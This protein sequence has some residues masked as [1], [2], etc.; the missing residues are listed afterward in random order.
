MFIRATPIEPAAAPHLLAFAQEPTVKV[1][2]TT[3]IRHSNIVRQLVYH[4]WQPGSYC[5]W[6]SDEPASS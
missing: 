5:I 3:H 1:G 6:Q 4:E 2:L